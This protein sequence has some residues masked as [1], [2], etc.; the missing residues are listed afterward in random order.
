[1]FRN[2]VN[3]PSFIRH[4]MRNKSFW[5]QAPREDPTHTTPMDEQGTTHDNALW[6]VSIPYINGIAK[7]LARHPH[8]LK[9]CIKQRPPVER[10]WLKPKAASAITQEQ[11]WY[12]SV[13]AK[14][15]TPNMMKKTCK[16]LKTKNQYKA[17]VHNHY[18][19]Y[20]TTLH[21][22]NTGQHLH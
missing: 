7:A 22:L 5:V 18:M 12:T 2:W 19:S 17:S 20:Q 14:A 6:W 8:K 1:M 10:P 15:A 9:W 21:G 13:N 3:P 11:G 4:L 16:T